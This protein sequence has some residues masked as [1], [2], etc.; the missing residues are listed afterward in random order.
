MILKN[1][2]CIDF[3]FVKVT[4][5]QLP[6]GTWAKANG[7]TGAESLEGRFA[8]LS[9]RGIEGRKSG[10]SDLLG[11]SVCWTKGAEVAW[12]WHYGVGLR[13]LDFP[14]QETFYN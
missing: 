7:G 12:H 1:R 13:L 11:L 4:G 3:H 9:G 10:R 5:R 6:R 8:V 2:F 14:F